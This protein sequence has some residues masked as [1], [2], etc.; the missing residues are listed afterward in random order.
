[1]AQPVRE[2]EWLWRHR[3]FRRRPLPNWMAEWFLRLRDTGVRA[4]EALLYRVEDPVYQ[5]PVTRFGLIIIAGGLVFALG[6][7][8]VLLLVNESAGVVESHYLAKVGEPLKLPPLPQRSTVYAADGSVLQHVYFAENRVVVPLSRYSESAVRA[9]LAIEDDG[10]FQHG[11]LDYAAI[12]RAGISDLVAGH[13]VEGGSTITQ[14]LVKDTVTGDAPTLARKLREAADAIRLENTYSK[15]RILGMYM[16]E[17]YLGHG[18]Y[19][20][21]AAAEYYFAERPSQLTLAQSALLAGLIRSPSY[22]DPITRPQHAVHRRNEVLLRMLNLGWI[23]HARYARAISAPIHL[24]D[25]GRNAAQAAPNSYWNQYVV[26]SFLSNPAFGPTVKARIQALYQGGLKIYTTLQ[27]KMQSEA[28]RVIAARMTGPGLPQSALV[29]IVPQTGAITTMAVGNAPYGENQYNLAVDP[30][31]GR[32]AGSAFKGFTLAAALE[33]G[34]SPDAV[35]DGNSPKTI[36]NCGGGETWT[37]H[38]AEPGGGSYPLWMATADSVNVVFAQVINQVGPDA[39]ARVAHRMGITSPLTPV[40]PL[41]LGTSPVSPLEMTSGYATL[42]NEGVHCQPYAIAKVLDSA[43]KPVFTQKPECTRAIPAWVAREETA[44]LEGVVQFGT[45]TAANIGRP[46]AGKTG[47]GQDYQDAW[48][49][50]YVPQLA[51]GVWVG[52][53]KAEIPM[54]YIPGYGTGF[55]GVLAAPIWHDYM[56]M[57]TRGMPSLSFNVPSIGFVMPA[58]APLPSASPS[59]SPSPSTA[60]SPTGSP[61]PLPSPTA[62]PTHG[63]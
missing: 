54:P 26:D 31:G 43:G 62:S 8:P 36:P 60:P 53:A 3:V 23:S 14:Q 1:M 28:E 50:G 42:A 29:S 19:G 46:Q 48:F 9:V 39:V 2:D 41:T 37:L 40:C 6:A 32:T 5:D 38:N 35:Y 57:A 15:E 20:L 22:Y 49:M 51:T 34:I 4:R 47:T 7:L 11:A 59:G 52:W 61:T 24:S 13:V 56:L 12:V 21:A 45:G 25:A 63:H 44:M 30:G 17:I 10:Y 18:A 58:P 33:A 16:S 27:P 55:G